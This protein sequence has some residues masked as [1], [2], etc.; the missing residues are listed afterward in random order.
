MCWATFSPLAQRWRI[1]SLAVLVVAVAGCQPPA[2][3][4]GHVSGR[5]TFQGQPVTAGTVNFSNYE[6]GVFMSA[7]LDDQGDYVVEMAQGYGLPVGTYQVT[8]VPLPP[9]VVTG[10]VQAPGS[11]PVQAKIKEYP[12]IPASY[13]DAK[14]SGLSVTVPADGIV[15]NIDMEP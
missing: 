15:F 8:V 10:I 1:P 4:L 9:E 5:V 13:R 14:T 7:R 12:N 11:V 3:R 2:V 6:S